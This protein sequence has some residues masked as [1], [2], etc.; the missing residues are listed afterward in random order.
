MVGDM[1]DGTAPASSGANRLPSPPEPQ[2]V[3]ATRR[4]AGSNADVFAAVA[5]LPGVAEAVDRARDAVDRLR[6]HRVLRR[7]AEK[8]ASESA[9]R[10]A[11]A[12][13][14]LDGA[15]VP[16]DVLRRTVTAG[17]RLP[18]AEEPGLRGAL[19]VAA[20]VGAL[21]GTWERAP[22]QALARLHA[23]AAADLVDDPQA[24]GRPE[25]GAAPR[26]GALAE[27]LTATTSAP[28]L[29]V[30]AVVHA[31]VAAGGA[32]PTGG[33]LVA[34]AAARL[35][36]VTRGLDPTAVS[37]PEVGHV[38]AGPGSYD[39]ALAA[40]REGGDGLRDW[41]LHC[42]DAVVLGAR[43]GIAVCEAIQRGAA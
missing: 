36:L 25:P 3:R 37:V 12:S 33:G 11:R 1:A 43:E 32:F 30:A 34:R 39:L 13:A 7:S 29:V 17:G 26:L 2:P 15:D 6:G 24:L 18:A 21:R 22:L 19:R 40:Y 42:A 9:L 10:G 38:D 27:A 14:A 20:E 28:A 4:S 8:V 5:E 35:T 16:L 31:E 23:L 41:V